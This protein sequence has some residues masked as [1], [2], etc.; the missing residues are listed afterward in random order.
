MKFATQNQALVYLKCQGE[1]YY[2]MHRV[3]KTRFWSCDEWR[4]KSCYTIVMK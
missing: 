3:V 1:R 2:G 4:W